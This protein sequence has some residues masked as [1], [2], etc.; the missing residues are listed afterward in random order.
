MSPWP[1]R[2]NTGLRR[3][4]ASQLVEYPQSRHRFHADV[5][6]E[7][8]RQRPGGGVDGGQH[9]CGAA[10]RPHVQG[11]RGQQEAQGV[12][13]GLSSS[14]RYTTPAVCSFMAG[15]PPGRPRRVSRRDRAAAPSRSTRRP[16]G[17]RRPPATL[18]RLQDG[19]AD[20]QTHAHAVGLG[21]IERRAQRLDPSA[22]QAG[23]VVAHFDPH[24]APRRCQAG[25]HFDGTRA[26]GLDGD[27]GQRIAGVANQVDDDL[28]DQDGIGRDGWQI[29]LQRQGE[30]QAL[31]VQVPLQQRERPG[32]GRH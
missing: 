27:L 22:Q 8:A 19:P 29:L 7:D 4:R 30:C 9:R 15:T 24:G 16:E 1:L 6:H 11:A 20:R 3:P 14:S 26:A 18:V 23:T 32:D 31:A 12:E 25:A 17:R 21:R 2:N 5:Q 28:L 10:E 13:H